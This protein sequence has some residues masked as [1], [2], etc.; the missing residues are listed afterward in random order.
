MRSG[1]GVVVLRCCLLALLGTSCIAASIW[2]WQTT[3]ED[4]KQPAKGLDTMVVET[5]NGHITVAG[6]RD[7]NE[8]AVHVIKKARGANAK[9]TARCLEAIEIQ[10][11]VKGNTMELGWDWATPKKR[12]WQASVAFEVKLPARLAVAATSHNG[13]IELA[14]TASTAT[15]LTHNGAVKAAKLAGDLKAMTHNGG[16]EVKNL[17]GNLDAKTYNGE[18]RAGCVASKIRAV[19]HNGAIDV[20][21]SGSKAIDG[22]LITHNGAITLRLGDQASAR[23][24]CSTQHGVVRA[25]RG[26][27]DATA[28]GRTALVGTVGAGEGS[29]EVKT[30]RGSITIK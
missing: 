29:L 28:R 25:E 9:D 2:A 3:E 8:V 26:L 23:I 17:R 13:K 4:F 16:I 11:T 15:L 20:D 22:Q 10:K 21:L 6:S 5:R 19:T 24:A 12:R 30:S 27:D 1:K 18:I 14:Q 7:T